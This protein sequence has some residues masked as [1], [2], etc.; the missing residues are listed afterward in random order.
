MNKKQLKTCLKIIGSDNS[1]PQEKEHAFNQVYWDTDVRSWIWRKAISFAKGNY[2]TAENLCQEAYAKLWEASSKYDPKRC[3]FAWYTTVLLNHF[4][5]LKKYH[6][7]RWS[8]LTRY[9]SIF[10]FKDVLGDDPHLK[11]IK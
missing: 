1:T 2:H 3:P 7:G 10:G 9:I 4:R 11:P 5:N 8:K 6:E